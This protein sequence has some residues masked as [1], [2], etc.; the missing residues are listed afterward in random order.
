MNLIKRVLLVVVAF[1]VA[2]LAVF[3]ILNWLGVER[4]EWRYAVAIG[5][6]VAIVGAVWRLTAQKDQP[7]RISN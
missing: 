1:G 7:P 2:N 5:V 4:G 3:V 6:I